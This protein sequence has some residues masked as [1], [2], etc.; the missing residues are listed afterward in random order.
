MLPLTI[1]EHNKSSWTNTP[2][3]S[4]PLAVSSRVETGNLIVV[5]IDGRE[6]RTE[7]ARYPRL[8]SANATQLA[9][10]RLVAQGVGIHWPDLDEDLSVAGMLRDGITSRPSAKTAQVSATALRQFDAVLARANAVACGSSQDWPPRG[11]GESSGVVLHLRGPLQHA[12]TV[13]RAQ[14]AGA[15]GMYYADVTPMAGRADR[16]RESDIPLNRAAGE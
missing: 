12:E 5:L 9:N 1:E 13:A 8:N 4:E 3:I 14:T 16:W 6:V 11:E 7:L 2:P 10:W 15:T